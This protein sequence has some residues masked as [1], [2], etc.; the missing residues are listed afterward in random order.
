MQE[1]GFVAV[2]HSLD[3]LKKMNQFEQYLVTKDNYTVAGICLI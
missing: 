3:D 1:Q 2:V